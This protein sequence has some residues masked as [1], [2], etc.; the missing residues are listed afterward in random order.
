MKIYVGTSDEGIKEFNSWS[1][2]SSYAMS[3]V[4]VHDVEKFYDK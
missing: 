4:N 2:V 1:E 3:K